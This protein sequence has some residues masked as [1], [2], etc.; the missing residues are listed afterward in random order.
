MHD[1]V[2]TNASR[3]TQDEVEDIDIDE[4]GRPEHL[5]SHIAPSTEDSRARSL[6]EGSE[7]ITELSREYLQDNENILTA[8]TANLHVRFE[9]ATNQQE[10]PAD[11]YR[12]Y[13]R[14]GFNCETLIIANCEII[15]SSQKLKRKQK[16]T[17]S[18]TRGFVL[19][20][21]TVS[22]FQFSVLRVSDESPTLFQAA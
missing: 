1:V 9:S 8:A 22:S 6:A 20:L 17:Q 13:R 21:Q 2:Q 5:W 19:H 3:Y 4:D 15:S 18:K 7:Q 14:T 10:I 11:Q 16:F 12:Q